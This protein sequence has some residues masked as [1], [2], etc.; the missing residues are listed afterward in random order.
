MAE[1]GF[2]SYAHADDAA[3]GGRIVDLA[4]DIE[5]QYRLITGQ[6]L[7][8]VLDATHLG[9]GDDWVAKID[10]AV[11]GTRFFMPVITPSYLQSQQCRREFQLFTRTAQS[12]GL[13]DLILSILYVDVP[14]LD[15]AANSDDEII[16]AVGRFQREDWRDLRFEDRSSSAYRRA[17]AMLAKRLS[18][19][20]PAPTLPEPGVEPRA[21]LSTDAEGTD[22]D[23]PG[24]LD[25]IADLETVMPKWT[26]TL[27]EVGT[28]I[29]AA[30]ELARDASD[31]M[32]AADARRQGVAGRLTAA[33]QFGAALAPHSQRV[34]E[35]S[36]DFTDGLY[37]MDAAVRGSLEFAL[38][39]KP[40]TQEENESRLD[41]AN[42]V[43]TLVS[44]AR[45]GLGSIRELIGSIEPLEGFS[46]D[47]RP[48][49]RQL[50]KA[51]TIMSEGQQVMDGW[52][53]L[54]RQVVEIYK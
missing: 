41:W 26:T 43:L 23:A 50:R 38:L 25:L 52:E 46:R 7:T 32:A 21:D 37:T 14:G 24:L 6:E 27:R 28:E 18:E 48:S 2:W 49:L 29:A 4:K 34:E 31:T 13:S 51:L 19:I 42:Q 1:N 17:V 44:A 33:R 35:L 20:S 12:V 9:W 11:I 5:A 3:E 10:A 16:K 47:M 8:I 53:P 22:E 39:G 40:D 54:A 45:E 30:G 15:D 36:S